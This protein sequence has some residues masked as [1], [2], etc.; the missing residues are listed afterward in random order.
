[1]SR[2]NN[3]NKNNTNSKNQA[4]KKRQGSRNQNMQRSSTIGGFPTATVAAARTQSVRMGLPKF[5]KGAT[6]STI[7]RHKELIGPV[8]GQAAQ[9]RVD[10]RLRINPASKV[11]FPWLSTIA[12]SFETYKFRRL[13]FKYIPRCSTASVGT[14]LMAPDY[15]AADRVVISEVEAAMNVDSIEG[16]FWQEKSCFLDPARMN[17]AYKQHYTADDARFDRTTQDA[18]TIDAGQLFVCMSDANN[19]SNG[20]LW[21]IYEIELFTP[22]VVTD[23]QSGGAGTN[24]AVGIVANTANVF[25]SNV[26][27]TNQ[28]EV[29]PIVSL[30]TNESFPGPDLFRFNKDWSGFITK[31]VN[32]SGITSLG[33]ITKNGVP[34]A[35]NSIAGVINNTAANGLIQYFDSFAKGDLLG[36]QT[37]NAGTLSSIIHNFGASGVV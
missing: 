24:K 14:I 17:A 27:Q 21:V 34:M 35:V 31:N 28:Q 4:P 11:T 25:T 19:N 7:I 37:I 2:K 13:E 5:S 8:T 12:N 22:Q 16:A 36:S 9:F 33:A 3:I 32:G 23:L 30:L 20:R 29:E 1:M 18:K 15:D 26:L 6:G 10:K